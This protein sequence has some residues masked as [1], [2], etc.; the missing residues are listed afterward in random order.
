MSGRTAADN[1]INAAFAGVTIHNPQ[2]LK[3]GGL[4]WNN[5]DGDFR[6]FET[7]RGKRLLRDPFLQFV[8]EPMHMPP[9]S[10]FRPYRPRADAFCAITDDVVPESPLT[11]INSYDAWSPDSVKATL[12]QTYKSKVKQLAREKIISPTQA[13]VQHGGEIVG[14][15]ITTVA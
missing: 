14:K 15:Y 13:R 6:S 11:L 3:S 12:T 9:S 5:V 10:A 2:P 8:G 1:E 7:E 4:L